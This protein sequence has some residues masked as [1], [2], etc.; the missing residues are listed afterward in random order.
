MKDTSTLTPRLHGVSHLPQGALALPAK[1]W[2]PNH[3]QRIQSSRWWFILRRPC[4]K[5]IEQRG[6]VARALPPKLWEL[7]YVHKVVERT[8][9]A[10]PQKHASCLAQFQKQHSTR[11]AK[12]HLV[13]LPTATSSFLC[14]SS[15]VSAFEIFITSTLFPYLATHI[16]IY[17]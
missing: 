8:H 4:S 3:Y 5:T 13:C 9:L 12:E 6:Q 15:L 2:V 1:A 16:Y 11:R 14:S 10:K 7:A 17:L